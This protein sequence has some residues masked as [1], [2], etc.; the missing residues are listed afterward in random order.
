MAQRW[1]I[2]HSPCHTASNTRTVN[3]LYLL[4]SCVLSHKVLGRSRHRNKSSFGRTEFHLTC[5][6]WSGKISKVFRITIVGQNQ[7]DQIGWFLKV[8]LINLLTIV[9]QKE[10]RL[11]GLFCK[12]INLWKLL[13]LQ[14]GQIF[15]AFGLLFNSNKWSHWQ[16]KRRH[17]LYLKLLN[18]DKN[19]IW[20][21]YD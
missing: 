15:K 6:I 4:C 7:C 8:L 3:V 12:K 11:L 1:K 14:F 20:G 21:D 13:W 2:I 17:I 10:W 5:H 9:A 19:F 16:N 18:K